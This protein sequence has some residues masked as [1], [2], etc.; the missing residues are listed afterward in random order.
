MPLW[1]ANTPIGFSPS[2]ISGIVAWYDSN[3]LVSPTQ[4]NDKTR[5]NN[6]LVSLQGSIPNGGS[7]GVQWSNTVFVDQTPEF[8]TIPTGATVFV[9]AAL[10]NTDAGSGTTL[11]SLFPIPLEANLTLG[12]VWTQPTKY[13][14]N[15][16]GGNK[17]ANGFSNITHNGGPNIYTGIC[18]N[19]PYTNTVN[20]N[21]YCFGYY[22]GACVAVNSNPVSIT[23]EPS[24]F[25]LQVGDT[26]NITV[27][28]GRIHS[29]N[30]SFYEVLFYNS[31]LSASDIRQVHLYLQQR[32]NSPSLANGGNF[33]Y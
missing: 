33:Q 5:Y 14:I 9:V 8:R 7:G 31:P 29:L 4:W 12:V 10:S 19:A 3:T 16:N 13:T 27:R 11:A 6:H 30:A 22:N 32:W 23:T 21:G 1:S 17:T 28:D 26:S 15:P 20:S 24:L 25:S 18:F 2:N